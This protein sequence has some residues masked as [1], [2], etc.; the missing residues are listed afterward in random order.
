[1]RAGNRICVLVLALAT[2]AG[3]APPA[4]LSISSMLFGRSR[5]AMQEAPKITIRKPGERSSDSSSSGGAKVSVRVRPKS[6]KKTTAP[7]PAVVDDMTTSVTVKAPT[8]VVAPPPPPP[9]LETTNLTVADQLLL[10]GTTKANCTII[11]EALQEGANPNVRDPKGRTPLHFVSGLGLA[12]A[13][14]LLIHFGAEVNARDAQDLTPLHM[15]AG[16]ANAQTLRVLVQAGADIEAVSEV[17]G[18]PL[19]IVLQLGEYQLTQFLNRTG[20]ER[21][22]K[23]DEKLESLKSCLDVFEDIEGVRAECDWDSMLSEVLSTMA[24]VPDEF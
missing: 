21:L 12:P 24:E 4:A 15:A 5:I 10:E 8:G 23:K 19:Q 14:V 7:E 16:Y 6:E 17:Q 1:M 13:A 9:G 11:L 3:F 20:T 2:A 22:K 18:K